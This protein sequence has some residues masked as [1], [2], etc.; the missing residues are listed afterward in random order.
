MVSECSDPAGKQGESLATDLSER[1]CLQVRTVKLLTSASALCGFRA[2][3]LERVALPGRQQQEMASST[4]NV[5]LISEP[6]HGA[7]CGG[8]AVC[9]GGGE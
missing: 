4:E 6:K 9:L 2:S 8:E 5:A 1:T 3:L 7:V